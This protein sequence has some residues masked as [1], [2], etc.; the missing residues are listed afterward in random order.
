MKNTDPWM[1]AKLKSKKHLLNTFFDFLSHFLRVWLQ[2]IQKV[3]IRPKNFFWKKSKKISKNTEFH[4]A[5]ESVDKVIKNAQKKVMNK[6]SLRNMSKS[7]KRAYFRHIF[8][9][10]F[11]SVHFSKLFQRIRNQ[12]EILHFLIPILNFLIIKIFLLILAL[13]VNFDCTCAEN[14]SKNWKSFFMNVS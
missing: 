13:F 14:S 2:S 10:N 12:R 6:A 11:C 7:K 5:F 3:L 1:D 8:A 4:A 9:N